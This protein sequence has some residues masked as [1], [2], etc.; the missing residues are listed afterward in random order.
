M[1]GR[2]KDGVTPLSRARG[3]GAGMGFVNSEGQ[4]VRGHQGFSVDQG[5]VPCPCQV[6]LQK[7]SPIP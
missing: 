3:E 4:M 6:P 1:P 7:A 2:H 5:S